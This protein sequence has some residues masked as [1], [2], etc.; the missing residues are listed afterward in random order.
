MSKFRPRF[1]FDVVI[2]GGLLGLMSQQIEGVIVG[3][4]NEFKTLINAVFLIV[5]KNELTVCNVLWHCCYA[6]IIKYVQKETPA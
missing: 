4:T 5:V 3:A 2:I 1:T 6:Y